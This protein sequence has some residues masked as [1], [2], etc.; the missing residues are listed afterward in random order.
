MAV[1]KDFLKNIQE[2]ISLKIHFLG[3][4]AGTEPV[5]GSR[6]LSFAIEKDD[7]LYWFDAGEGSSYTAHLM[8]LDLLSIKAIFISHSHMD[9]IGGL[10]NLLWNIRKINNREGGKLMTGKNIDVFMSNDRAWEGLI[11]LLKETE[12]N[13]DIDFTI[14]KKD[15]EDGILFVQDGFKVEAIHNSHLGTPEDGKWLS[16]SFRISAEGKNIVFTGDIGSYEDIDP[17]IEGCDL[18]LAETGHFK[19]EEV[20]QYVLEKGDDIKKL[21]FV[22]NG[23]FILKDP[24]GELKKAKEILGDRVFVARDGMTLEFQ[25]NSCKFTVIMGL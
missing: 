22:H 2:M 19:P 13:F 11:M 1:K 8:G 4:C 12:G 25:K 24:E 10:G 18:L 5:E 7:K 16:H 20:C 23:R 6:H 15:L 3:T 21:G 17:I 14:S 9:H